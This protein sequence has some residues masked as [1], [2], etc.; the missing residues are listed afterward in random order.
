[1]DTL[2]FSLFRDA[3]LLLRRGDRNLSL[4]HQLLG[5]HYTCLRGLKNPS[6]TEGL[7]SLHLR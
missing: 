5:D 6:A 4:G 1:L 2:K 3:H 7:R